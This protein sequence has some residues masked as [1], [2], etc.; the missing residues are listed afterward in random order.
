MPN[1]KD[2]VLEMIAAVENLLIV[3]GWRMADAESLSPV[4]ERR[5]AAQLSAFGGR[6]LTRFAVGNRHHSDY[7]WKSAGCTNCKV[8]G[9]TCWFVD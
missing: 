5:M 8:A 7:E 3:L 9:I 4:L 1:Q 2:L 6:G